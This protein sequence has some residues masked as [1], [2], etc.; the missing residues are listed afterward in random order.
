M[1]YNAKW[2]FTD[3][4]HSQGS[5]ICPGYCDWSTNTIANQ[6]LQTLA[7]YIA[8]FDADIIF[9]EEVSDCWVLN[10]LIN[11]MPMITIANSNS[12]QFAKDIYKPYLLFG[13]DT[14]TGQNCAMITKIDPITDLNR[15]D[16]RFDYP[17]NG[18]NCGYTT[19]NNNNKKNYG[20]TKHF[21]ADFNISGIDSIITMIGVHFLSKPTDKYNCAKREAQASVIADIIKTHAIA[22]GYE[23]L[24]SGDFNDYADDIKDSE[25]HIPTSR[26]TEIIRNAGN[27]TNVLLKIKSDDDEED[28]DDFNNDIIYS[29][30]YD[31]KGG[32]PELN[33][34]NCI[35]DGGIEHSLIDQ[36]YT[37]EKLYNLITEARI[38]HSYEN[39]CDCL[40]SDHWPIIVDFDLSLSKNGSGHGP[41]RNI[42]N[43]TD[44][45][46]D[47]NSTSINIDINIASVTNKVDTSKNEN[48]WD[49]VN[50]VDVLIGFG[51]IVVVVAVSIAIYV[52]CVRR[53]YRQAVAY[54]Q[55]ETSNDETDTI[56]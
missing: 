5:L 48:F 30:W 34:T 39:Y 7:N 21:Y 10:Q 45:V 33:D 40:Y 49:K 37:S 13:K 28:D 15:S 32:S 23:V 55:M 24:V 2:L 17:L 11:N 51:V 29:D 35:D 53:K 43:I 22:N 12:N 14:Y 25:N 42:S 19:S 4:R 46:D 20:C 52:A 9:L 36:F 44:I 56:N 16:A 27:L 18:S 3:Y 50:W 6:H 26:V 41:G 38:D 1:S 47:N 8:T 31:Q 54:A